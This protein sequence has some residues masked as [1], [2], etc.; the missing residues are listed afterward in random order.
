MNG[1]VWLERLLTISIQ[2]GLIIWLAGKLDP[3]S[4]DP[5][6]S[7][8]VWM[9]ALT[10]IVAVV[11]LNA[12]LPKLYWFHPWGGISDT[13]RLRIGEAQNLLGGLSVLIWITGMSLFFAIWAVR[14]LKVRRL[15]R[16][17]REVAHDDAT[18]STQVRLLASDEVVSP[19]C[20]QLHRPVIV[21]PEP[22][23]N[24]HQT[25][26]NCVLMHETAHLTAGHPMQLFLHRC[27]NMVGWFHPS[28]RIM[29]D[30][31]SLARECFC[32]DFAI[33]KGCR[34]ADYLKTLVAAATA[35]PNKISVWLGFA[36]APGE[37][38]V[39]A[40]R[41]AANRY[42][43]PQPINRRI[44]DAWYGIVL[45]WAAIVCI[46][47]IDLPINAIRSP[48]AVHSGWPTP[49]AQALQAFGYE[50]IDFEPFCR[51]SS[52]IELRKETMIVEPATDA[53]A[54]PDDG[55]N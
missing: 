21:L 9:R 7:G 16:R 38:V 40:R 36:S 14:S 41:I 35:E 2:V 43:T 10:A 44:G 46:G 29:G 32:D 37:L 52:L 25:R 24:D 20:Y 3:G 33:A 8:R 11:L 49:V 53:T 39:R 6:A 23:L 17:G 27:V 28:I 54:V 45:W 26:V 47:L 18:L 5:K 34:P 12:F 15:I 4:G 50:A 42:Q 55:A 48:N 22:A 31:L 1:A 13:L 51:Q 19:F 30:S